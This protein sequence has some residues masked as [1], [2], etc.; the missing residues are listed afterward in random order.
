MQDSPDMV[1]RRGYRDA[2]EQGDGWGLRRTGKSSWMARV[3]SLAEWRGKY[4]VDRDGD[5]II[6]LEDVCVDVETDEPMFGTV[7]EGRF[8]RYPTFLPLGGVT[9]GPDDVQV[10]VSREQVKGAPGHRRGGRLALAGRRGDAL[11]PTTSSTTRRRLASGRRLAG[12]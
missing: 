5:R 11:S 1:P 9:I 6:R 7:K 4:L 12:R 3:R 2:G 8:G 10:T